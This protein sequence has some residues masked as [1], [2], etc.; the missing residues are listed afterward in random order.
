MLRLS[1]GMLLG[2]LLVA[3]TLWAEAPLVKR[4]DK[5]TGKNGAPVDCDYCH[6]VAGNP[7][8]GKNYEKYKKG[9]FCAIKGCH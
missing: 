8:D 5:L 7:K 3:G 2:T 6:V 9:P 1:I 4:H